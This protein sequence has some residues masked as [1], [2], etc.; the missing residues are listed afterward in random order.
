MVIGDGKRG[1][2]YTKVF[3]YLNFASA[4]EAKCGLQSD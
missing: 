1:L 3:N 4:M 2:T